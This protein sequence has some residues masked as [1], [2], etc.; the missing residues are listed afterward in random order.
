[1]IE[2][3][4]GIILIIPLSLRLSLCFILKAIECTFQMEMSGH[5]QGLGQVANFPRMAILNFTMVG[6]LYHKP[7]FMFSGEGIFDE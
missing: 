1:M 4:F 7:M 6:K 2:G 5:W 3:E